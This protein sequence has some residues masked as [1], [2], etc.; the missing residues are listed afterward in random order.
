MKILIFG[1]GGIGGYFGARLAEA[2]EEVVFVARGAFAEA[3]HR[4]GLRIFSARGDLHLK[5]VAVH[6]SAETTGAVDAVLICTKMWSL[7]EAAEAIRPLL[8]PD[9]AVVPLQNGVEAVDWLS[10]AIGPENLL[11]GVAYISAHIEAP[12]TIRHNTQHARIVFGELDGRRSARAEAL[13]EAL[14]RAGIDAV[15]TDDVTRALWEKFSTLAPLAGAC[16]YF[17][18][19]IAG[20]RDSAGG[21]ELLQ[22]LAGECIA[23][24]RAR[25]VALPEGWEDKVYA[26]FDELGGA[27]KPSMLVDLERGNPLELEWLSGATLRL[28]EAT[29]IDTPASRKVYNELRPFAEGRSKSLAEG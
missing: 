5:P 13:Y 12:G 15:L 24:G 27:V 21:R 9:T 28:G 2:G 1:S 16:S 6:E 25:G 20:V 29:D 26:R 10:E 19:D 7:P 14:E 8:T 22:A 17:R 18:K 23:V 3:L 11:G 4:D